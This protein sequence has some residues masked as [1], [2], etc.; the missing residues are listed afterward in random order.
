ALDFYTQY[1]LSVQV[2]GDV[3]M[4]PRQRLTSSAYAIN[5]DR[6]DRIEGRLFLRSDIDDIVEGEITFTHTGTPIIIQPD[7][8]PVENTKLINIPYPDGTSKFSVDY[9]GDVAVAGELA[10]TGAATL[11]SDLD[12]DGDFYVSGDQTIVGTTSYQGP[13]AIG[14]DGAGHDVTF[15]GS[16]E[17]CYLLWDASEDDLTLVGT[18]SLQVDNVTIEHSGALSGTV[19]NNVRQLRGDMD[20]GTL[21]IISDFFFLTSPDV[22][23]D[24]FNILTR[25]GH[26]NIDLYE[27]SNEGN[28]VVDGRV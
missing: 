5:A 1:W 17:G 13:M 18:T 25:G 15:Y 6:L 28:F 10:V 9:E 21:G 4:T 27:D 11:R 23:P 16:T 26:F 22:D 12:V 3:E 19:I 24:S 2:S 20:G 7:P 8:A 14:A